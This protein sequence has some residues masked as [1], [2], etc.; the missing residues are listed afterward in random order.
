MGGF[1]GVG[2]DLRIV[3]VPW[4]IAV[5]VLSVWL[6]TGYRHRIAFG[7]GV[8]GGIISAVAWGIGAVTS[9]PPAGFVIGAVLPAAMSVASVTGWRSTFRD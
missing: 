3:F 5:A 4:M 9:T 2:I 6:L 1:G 8:I 7:F